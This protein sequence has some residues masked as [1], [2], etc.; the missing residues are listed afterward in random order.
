MAIHFLFTVNGKIESLVD[1]HAYMRSKIV[2]NRSSKWLIGDSHLDKFLFLILFIN[3]ITVENCNLEFSNF[4][5]LLMSQKPFF[6]SLDLDRL[7]TSHCASYLL[8]Y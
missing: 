1:I 3:E 2:M 8:F 5:N 7:V 4:R 6:S